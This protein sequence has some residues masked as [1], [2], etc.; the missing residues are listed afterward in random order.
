MKSFIEEKN[1]T[2]WISGASEFRAQ[3]EKGARLLDWEVKTP[4]G[5]RKIIFW[6]ENADLTKTARARGGNPI[7]FPF[8]ARTYHKKEANKWLAPDGRVLDMPQNGFARDCDFK[9][10]EISD[11]GFTAELIQDEKNRDFYPFEYRFHVSYT[12][13]QLSMKVTL[14]F[15]N[16]DQISLPWCAGHHF[17]FTLPWH[18]SLDRGSYRIKIPSKKVFHRQSD[19]SLARYK[20]ASEVTVFSDS[21]L[22]DRLHTHLKSNIIC[23][24]PKSEEEDIFIRIGED[25]IPSAWCSVNTWRDVESKDAYFCVEP[26]MGPPN[27]LELNKGVHWVLPGQKEVFQTEISLF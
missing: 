7:L 16:D 14:T 22:I 2:R 4:S 11:S 19:G 23:F 8:V 3:P 5:L 1:F 13:D 10:V 26:W 17:Y 18:K 21:S 6:P 27:G 15:F 24:G 20:E 12:F 25:R 9:I